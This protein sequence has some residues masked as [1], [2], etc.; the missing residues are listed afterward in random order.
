MTH[1]SNSTQRHILI[2]KFPYSSTYGGGEKHMLT[3]VERLRD[4]HDFYLLSTCSVLLPEFRKRSWAT[5]T[6]WAGIEP[7]TL[8]A[9]LWFCFT[10][11]AIWFNLFRLL[12]VYKLRHRIDT[13]F[14]LSLTEKVLLTPW[15]RLL[16]MKV[17]WMEHLQIERWL[18]A[19]PLRLLYI[20]WS[21]F[22]TVVTVVEA[23]KEQLKK[24]G[25]PD[26]RITVIYNAVDTKAFPPSPSSPH[27]LGE[28]FRI[29]FIGRLATEKGIDDLLHAVAQVRLTIPP[30][31]LTLVGDGYW[32]PDLETLAQQLKIADIVEFA[33]FQDNIPHWMKQCDVLVLPSI[34]RETFGIVI[35]EAFATVK[36]VVAT[37][38]GGL[39]EIVDRYGWLVPPHRPQALAEALIDVHDNYQLAVYKASSGRVRVLELFQE[40]RM[41]QEYDA[42]FR[43]R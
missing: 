2:L 4:R 29:L 20:L 7:V 9:L 38:T 15:A 43:N 12:I 11:P 36:P 41:I 37:T 23:V 13:L 39:T 22:A 27:T 10:A 32:R 25:V 16:G 24:L 8:H 18:T 40:K 1:T 6:T 42:L 28:Q 19:N 34:R 26:N 30:V 3:L 31:H 35:I 14:C 33:G 17:I 21:R 5:A